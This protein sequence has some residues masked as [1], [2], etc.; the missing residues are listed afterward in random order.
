MAMKIF[1]IQDQ[2]HLV[3]W[4]VER[5]VQIIYLFG[6]FKYKSEHIFLL[7]LK[8]NKTTKHYNLFIYK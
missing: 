8:T 1:E 5:T 4:L 6:K 7:L 2:I 3:M